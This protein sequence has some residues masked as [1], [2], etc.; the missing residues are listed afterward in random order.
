MIERLISVLSYNPKEPMIFSSGTFLILFL[1]FTFFYMLLQKK[2]T[3]RLLFVTAF[4]YYFY[5]KSS[6]MYFVLLA[7]VTC[8]DYIIAGFIYRKRDGLLRL[9]C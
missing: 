1:F 6:G 2:L 4:S 3:P 8:S 5:Y 9:V 7:I